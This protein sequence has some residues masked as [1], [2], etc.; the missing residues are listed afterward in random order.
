MLFVDDLGYGDLGFTGHPTT[1]TPNIDSLAYNGKIL[2]SWYSG[3]PVC[4]GSRTAL[5]T[6][7]QYTRVGVPGVF[8]DSSTTGLPLNETT[9]ADQLKKAGYKN[10]IMGKWHLGQRPMFL[11]GARGFD[12]YLGIPYSDD[13]GQAARSPCPGDAQ[14]RCSVIEPSDYKY[15]EADNV[16]GEGEIGRR[17]LADLN[18]N[19]PQDLSPL[20]FQTGGTSSTPGAQ[21]KTA[22]YAKNTTVLEQPVDFSKL[23]PK[24]NEFVLDFIDENKEDPFF[25]YMPFSHVHTTASNQP[26]K[27]YAACQFQNTSE[28]G[29][30][31]DALAEVDWIVGNVVDKLKEHGLMK[32]TLVLFTGDNGPWM[33][34]GL[35]GGSAGLFVGRYSGYWNTGKGSTWD[36]G[37][38]EAA[39]AHWEG[40]I[41]PGSRT[42]EVTSSMDLFPTASALAGVPL[43]TDRVYDGRDM[44]D[45]LL[46]DNGKSKHDVLFFYG[47]GGVKQG[48]SAARMGCWKAHWGTA[49]GMGG[50][51]IGAGVKT[52]CP[53][54]SYDAED[55][56]LFNV[57]IDPSEGIPLAGAKPDASDPGPSPVPVPQA[58]IDLA[59]SQL[60][61]AYKKE[62]ATFE[63]GQLVEPD[64]LPGE[65]AGV[66]VCC[67]KNPFKQAPDKFTCDCNGAPYK[68]TA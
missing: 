38:H 17:N 54:V 56:L 24:Y 37:I 11:P 30:F 10:A 27:Q 36:G 45:V 43:P 44:S 16:H 68:C 35:S 26:Q 4:S 42:A 65:E 62:L 48:P 12:T 53:T 1:S 14:Q 7:R 9:V 33:V 49:P 66:R 21:T 8:G 50:C 67:D 28:R 32:N 15:T 31:G 5:M 46:K 47:G 18:D 22:A 3:C 29:A 58:E 2:N 6:G 57:C 39:F 55:P 61:A 51:Q 63:R 13:M 52:N 64:L 19:G 25:L 41:A 59:K 60:V 20:V 40:M 23:A 34:Q